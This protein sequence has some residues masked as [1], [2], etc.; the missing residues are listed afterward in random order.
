MGEMSVRN[1]LV[2]EVVQHSIHNFF[3]VN[4]KWV[5][6]R[7]GWQVLH[8][9][10]VHILVLEAQI[11]RENIRERFGRAKD[12]KIYRRVLGMQGRHINDC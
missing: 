9:E 3:G 5:L 8:C 4:S 6:I 1:S 12:W 2:S 10:N 7:F 11:L